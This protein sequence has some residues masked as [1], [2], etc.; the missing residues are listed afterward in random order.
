MFDWCQHINP[1][2]RGL[3]VMRETRYKSVYPLVLLIFLALVSGTPTGY[4]Q[5]LSPPGAVVYSPQ[6]LDQLLAPIALYPDALLAPIL[7][8]ATYPL[9]VIEAYRWVSAPNHS[10]LRGDELAAALEDQD[11][12]PS[13]KALVPF[14]QVL[15]MMNDQLGWMQQIGDAF[16]AQQVDVMNAVQRL[17]AQAIAAGTLQAMDEQ[18]VGSQDQA[19]TIAPINPET[20]YVPVYDPTVYG[21]WPYPDYPPDYFVP[22]GS[23]VEP[24]AF[25]WIPIGVVTVLWGWD[26]WDWRHHRIHIDPD[27]YKRLNKGKG[28]PEH[29]PHATFDSWAHDPRHRR[30]VPYRDPVT[31]DRFRP[32]PGGSPAPRLNFRGFEAPPSVGQPHKSAGSHPSGPAPIRQNS[33]PA[34]DRGPV[35]FEDDTSGADARAASERGH[36]SRQTMPSFGKQQPPRPS[37]PQHGGFNLKRQVP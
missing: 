23:I 16:L 1:Y 22:P 19:I 20:V 26:H 15:G 31:L 12:D 6:Q 24:G 27:R 8:A 5:T 10:Q 29:R 37:S 3:V 34:R 21:P 11:W 28:E 14:P 2:I 36:A 33:A 18:I 9:E 17:R 4:T 13:V 32:N 30:G 25:T 7:M 35:V